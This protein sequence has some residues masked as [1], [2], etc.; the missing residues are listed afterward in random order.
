MRNTP[1]VGFNQE[2]AKRVGKAKFIKA[3]EDVYPDI[4]LNAEWDKIQPPKT[5]KPDSK[6]PEEAKEK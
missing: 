5:G 1:V 6:E 3:F 4:D 2:W